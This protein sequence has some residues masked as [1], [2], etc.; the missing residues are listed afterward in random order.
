MAGKNSTIARDLLIAPMIDAGQSAPGTTSRGAIQ[1]RMP[2]RS[3]ATH[4]AS[5]VVWSFL[6]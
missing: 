3:K 6:E 2:R 4:A 1:T 5:A